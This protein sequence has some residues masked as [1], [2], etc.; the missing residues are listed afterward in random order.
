MVKRLVQRA[1]AAFQARPRKR[2]HEHNDWA[3]AMVGAISFL[4]ASY[5]G[6]AVANVLPSLID[7]TNQHG[8]T[9]VGAA[10]FTFLGFLGVSIW[11]FGCLAAHCHS[12]L[13]ERHFR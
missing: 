4:I 10:I 9:W 3:L 8:L 6:M 5:W 13:Y 12:L 7:L 1:I 2:L 11:F